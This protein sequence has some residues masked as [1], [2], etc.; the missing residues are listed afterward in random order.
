MCE[1]LRAGHGWKRTAKVFSRRLEGGRA[2]PRPLTL[3]DLGVCV[4]P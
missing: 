4:H 3:Q 1:P 2:P